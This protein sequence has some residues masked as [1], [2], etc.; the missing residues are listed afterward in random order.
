MI[1][2]TP[3]QYRYL[4]EED[5]DMIM[6]LTS[7]CHGSMS[8]RVF[9]INNN[10]YDYPECPY[11]FEKLTSKNWINNGKRGYRIFCSKSCAMKSKDYIPII[12]KR[13]L[14]NLEKYGSESN[15][16]YFPAFRQYLKDK[17]GIDHV[18]IS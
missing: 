9:W 11:C 8:E 10:L 17:Y 4:S 3:V 7:R 18:E 13:K 1:K 16:W 14:T 2:L 15:P 12:E 5:K 6:S